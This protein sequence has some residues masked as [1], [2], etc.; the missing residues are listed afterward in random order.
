M[1]LTACPWLS[2]MGCVGRGRTPSPLPPSWF[3]SLGGAKEGGE[4]H[5]LAGRTALS[6]GPRVSPFVASISNSVWSAVIMLY[7]FPQMYCLLIID[8]G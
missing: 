2:R 8:Q 1:V 5:A 4:Q 7:F 6:G 3:P